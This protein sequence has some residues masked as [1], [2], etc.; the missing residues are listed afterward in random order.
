F[1]RFAIFPCEGEAMTEVAMRGCGAWV[2]LDGGFKC[3]ERFFGAP[4]HHAEIAEGDL[5]PAGAVVELDRTK[6]VLAAGLQ[7]LVA[8]DP[9][10][11]GRKHQAETE[12]A[13][14]R[15]VVR[16]AIHGALQGVDRSA[17]DL[18]IEPP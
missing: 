16:V 3:R 13:A 7:T 6:C 11:V 17:I 2:E 14:R 12:Q 4:L 18:A 8:I 5:S 15:F 9:A 1:D 10:V